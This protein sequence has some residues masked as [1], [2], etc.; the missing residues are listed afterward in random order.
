[1]IDDMI[2]YELWDKAYESLHQMGP[3]SWK[4]Q[5]TIDLILNPE[6]IYNW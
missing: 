6:I 3:W 1:M 4:E 5:W 2:A